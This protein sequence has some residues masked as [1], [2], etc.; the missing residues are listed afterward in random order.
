M[1]LSLQIRFLR[2]KPVGFF[3]R[4]FMRDDRTDDKGQLQPAGSS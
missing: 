1:Y 3:W 4:V 2:Q